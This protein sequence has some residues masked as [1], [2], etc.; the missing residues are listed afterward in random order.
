VRH[1]RSDAHSAEHVLLNK[2]HI[3]G[4]APKLDSYSHS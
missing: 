2:R 1:L 4:G 3:L